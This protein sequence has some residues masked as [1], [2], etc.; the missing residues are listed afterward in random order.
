MVRDYRWSKV[1]GFK[2]RRFRFELSD[3]L[4]QLGNRMRGFFHRAIFSID[5][6]R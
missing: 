5:G 2:P 6:Q 4:F 1:E 3:P